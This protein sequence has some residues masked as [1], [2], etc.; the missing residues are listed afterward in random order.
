MTLPLAVTLP[1]AESRPPL[2]PTLPLSP[3]APPLASPQ[4]KSLGGPLL[5][6][7]LIQ[8]AAL[9][10]AA[11]RIPLSANYMRAGERVAVEWVLA[12]QVAGAAA[13]FPLLFRSWRSALVLA[14]S[15][16]L[17][18]ALASGLAALPAGRTVAAGTYVTAWL[19]ALA[20]WQ[21]ALPPDPSGK[22]HFTAAAVAT[23][24]CAGGPALWYLAAEFAPPGVAAPPADGRFGPMLAALDCAAAAPH[25]AAD[26]GY[27]CAILVAGILAGLPRLRRGP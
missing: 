17:F 21:V 23:M 14:A 15:S 24:L 26:G 22:W 18:L 20:L 8:L 2:S 11:S 19:A 9:A 4:T 1:A 3:T 25:W 10:L 12:A 5:A 13:L 27:V 16:W 7:S 6:W